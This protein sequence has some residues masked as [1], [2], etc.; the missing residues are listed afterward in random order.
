MK[1]RL[2]LSI[3]IMLIATES[4]AMDQNSDKPSNLEKQKASTE[5]ETKK[6]KLWWENLTDFAPLSIL[7]HQLE[8][9]C[10]NFLIKPLQNL[11]I[12]YVGPFPDGIEVVEVK[13][14]PK[15][16]SRD[17]FEDVTVILKS[18][19]PFWRVNG[20]FRFFLLT[21]MGTLE[22][23]KLAF[24]PQLENL[25][26]SDSDI[27]NLYKNLFQEDGEETEE[28]K[29]VREAWFQLARKW[30]TKHEAQFEMVDGINRAT[31]YQNTAPVGSWHLPSDFQDKWTRLLGFPHPRS[32][33]TFLLS[34]GDG[35]IAG[36]RQDYAINQ[37]A[38]L[39]A[40][41][42]GKGKGKGN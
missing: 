22:Q 8:K 18:G 14:T 16:D 42:R 36:F 30:G 10:S 24:M 19:I 2:V 21:G 20:Q 5:L 29:Q 4:W 25:G 40:A 35:Y 27:Q 28:Q 6:E 11:V 32:A 34:G 26:Y 39:V 3:V 15:K 7:Q 23:Q 13:G 9:D 31:W 17:L 41:P 33:H 37:G 1:N 12:E 38:L